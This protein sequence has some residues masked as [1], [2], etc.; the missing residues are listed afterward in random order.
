MLEGLRRHIRHIEHGVKPQPPSHAAP[1]HTGMHDIPAPTGPGASAKEPGL[2]AATRRA[3]LAE[4]ALHPGEDCWTFGD[5]A[6]DKL[7][8]GGALELAALH[9]IKPR[10]YGDWQAAMVL[11]LRLASR[12]P[13]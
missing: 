8:P 7:L 12:R 11:A 9:E 4:W 13:G 6:L 1:A 3:E 10:D 5:A 2:A